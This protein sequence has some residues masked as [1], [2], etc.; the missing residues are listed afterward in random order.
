[1]RKYK[2]LSNLDKSLLSKV[3]SFLNANIKIKS[4]D[5]L[6]NLIVML[7]T[8]DSPKNNLDY[9]LEELSRNALMSNQ[10]IYADKKY[11]HAPKFYDFNHKVKSNRGLASLY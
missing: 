7:K 6:F 9:Y 2:K 10:M 3:A 11:G 5:E 1:M 4:S 8:G